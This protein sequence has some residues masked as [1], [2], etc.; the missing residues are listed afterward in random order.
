M[1]WNYFSH[2]IKFPNTQK[3]WDASLT[4]KTHV[5]F[6]NVH[7][8]HKSKGNFPSFLGAIP[9]FETIILGFSHSTWW[10]PLGITHKNIIII[11]CRFYI[12]ES[13]Q[14]QNLPTTFF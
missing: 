8:G 9:F 13:Q 14:L 12:Q 11:S 1:E 10:V 5:M 2:F 3:C 7:I 4:C 6:C